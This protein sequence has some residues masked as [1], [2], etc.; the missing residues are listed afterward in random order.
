LGRESVERHLQLKILELVLV[1]VQMII[2]TLSAFHPRRASRM[3]IFA[4][5]TLKIFWTKPQKAALES[6][7]LQA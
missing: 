6:P 7:K 4:R 2:L 1:C 3:A 5:V